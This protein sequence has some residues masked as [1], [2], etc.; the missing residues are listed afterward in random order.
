MTRMLPP[1]LPRIIVRIDVPAR[2]LPALEKVTTRFG[3]TQV[4]AVSRL[5]EWFGKLD[6]ATREAILASPATT[7]GTMLLLRRLSN[8]GSDK[9]L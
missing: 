7:E 3:M 2:T 9:S 1:P 6:D 4:S 8:D 5:V